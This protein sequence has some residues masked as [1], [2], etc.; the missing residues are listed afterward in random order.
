MG[1]FEKTKR[2]ITKSNIELTM[3]SS[4]LASYQLQLQQVEA[5]LTAD[6]ENSELL[7]LKADLEQ[8]IEL[9]KELVS[10]EA[11]E[12]TQ[13]SNK[14]DN[15]LYESSNNELEYL[16]HH[17]NAEEEKAI[18]GNK[19]KY[20]LEEIEDVRQ[21]IKHWQVGEECQAL[22]HKDGQYY[23]ATIE[24]ITTDGEVSVRFKKY[25]NTTVT[26]LVLL[27]AS[28]A[29]S[30]GQ[31]SAKNKKEEIAKQREYLKKQNGKTSQAKLL[32]NEAL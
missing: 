16:D 9:T 27:K 19:R 2:Q 30:S 15:C 31:S 1:Y 29:G 22:S 25:N 11:G 32:A 24:E 14:H 17:D 20:N 28:T 7:P 18:A 10:T 6:P 13:E 23:D 12:S 4:D 8:V 21:P 5:A 3:A 26:T